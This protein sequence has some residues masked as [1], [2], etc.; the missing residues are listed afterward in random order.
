[1]WS[2][3]RFETNGTRD[4][5]SSRTTSGPTAMIASA[6]RHV[7]DTIA[8]DEPLLEV[9]GA[10]L[11]AQIAETMVLNEIHLQTVIASKAALSASACSS[12]SARSRAL[13]RMMSRNCKAL[14][15]VMSS[16]SI[17]KGLAM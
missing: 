11:E 6:R 17:S 3:T 7:G 10:I 9:T 2:L 4:T 14:A 8:L 1:M 5:R 12:S 16:S 15:T 13:S